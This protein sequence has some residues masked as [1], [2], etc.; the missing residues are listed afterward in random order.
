MVEEVRWAAA[1]LLPYNVAG[2]PPFSETVDSTD[3]SHIYRLLARVPEG[4]NGKRWTATAQ[5]LLVAFKVVPL[6]DGVFSLRY[7]K[8]PMG[9]QAAVGP[10]ASGLLMKQVTSFVLSPSYDVEEDSEVLT[11]INLTLECGSIEIGARR[12]N[13]ALPLNARGPKGKQES[14]GGAS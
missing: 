7:S 9:P 2:I 11:G 13:I 3:G 4:D 5:A 8:T 6:E 14:T 12:A 10:E 1:N